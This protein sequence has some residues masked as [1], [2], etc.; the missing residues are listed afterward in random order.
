VASRRD[1]R[2]ACGAVRRR[3]SWLENRCGA[4]GRRC[5]REAWSH[6]R[7]RR[8]R[9]HAAA[10][11]HRRSDT[12]RQSG[13]DGRRRCRRLLH[14]HAEGRLG[15]G[16]EAS[17]P[18][19]RTR[20]SSTTTRACTT[21]TSRDRGATVTTDV[22]FIGDKTFTVTLGDGTYFFQ[23]DPHS[24]QMRGLFTVG[25]VT[26]TTTTAPTPAPAPAPA[27]AKATASIAV[28]AATFRPSTGLSAG[29]FA[30]AV[31]DRSATDGFRLVGPGV[32]KATGRRSAARSRGP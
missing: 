4:A 26:T 1:R 18:G 7:C 10:R 15:P 5:R 8:R 22:E 29:T 14:D 2:C 19:Q 16:S 3:A 6:H 13:A 9:L 20:S 31:N 12:R 23:C 27:A 24:A 17:R 11:R 25:A 30:I 32:S 28:S 21:S